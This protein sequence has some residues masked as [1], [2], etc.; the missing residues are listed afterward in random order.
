MKFTPRLTAPS[1]TD[2]R[3]VSYK[4]GGYNVC[5]V[6]DKNTGSVIPNCVGYAHGRLLEI[7][8]GNKVNWKIPACN[9]EDWFSK[10]KENGFKTGSTPKLGAVACWSA[11]QVKNGADGAG[12]VAVVEEI[13]AN[14]DIVTSNSAYNGTEFYTKTVTKASGYVYSSSRPLVGFIYCGI[15]FENP[16][17]VT[18]NKVELNNTACYTSE[19]TKTSYGK[20]TGTFYLWDDE[21]R[22]GRIRIT[23][24]ADRV[25][26]KGQVTCWVA[27]SDLNLAYEESKQADYQCIHTV[28]KGETFWGL[29]VKYLGKGSRY[30]EVLELNGLDGTILDIGQKLKIPN[31]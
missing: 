20:K 4:N 31:K 23:N 17:I 5:I 6:I 21:V 13:K 19:S 15:E 10:A 25:G 30:P 26:V 16:D 22:N 1:K 7:L 27:V 24:K 11:G 9:A 2:K 18:G 12:H 14:G 29:A 28:K 8:G 3:Y